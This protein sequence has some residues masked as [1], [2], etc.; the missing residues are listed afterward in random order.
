MQREGRFP[1]RPGGRRLALAPRRKERGDR[2]AAPIYSQLNRP[3]AHRI[4]VKR[5]RA[6]RL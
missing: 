3:D 5:L 1:G 6:D 2:S 4:P